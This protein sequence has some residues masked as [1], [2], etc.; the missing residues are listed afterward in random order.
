MK[1]F[2]KLLRNQAK[3]IYFAEYKKPNQSSYLLGLPGN[4]AA[5]FVCLEIHV[6]TLLKAMQ[7]LKEAKPEW[8]KASLSEAVKGDSREQL[9]R[10]KLNV[11]EQGQT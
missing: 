8:E 2:G 6:L 9:L 11:D 1:F 7:G 5:V 10:M 3:P 4:P